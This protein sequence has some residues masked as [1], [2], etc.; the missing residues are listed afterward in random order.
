MIRFKDLRVADQWRELREINPMHYALVA[1]AADYAWRVHNRATVITS[2]YRPDPESVHGWWRGTDLRIEHRDRI[3]R[4]EDRGWSEDIAADTC[5]WLARAFDYG[6]GHEVYRI[7]GEGMN[8]H[9]H[10]QSP[11]AERWVGGRRGER[12]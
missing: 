6:V 12:E 4:E 7:H 2:I 9:V 8:R 11:A 3:V 1:A 10:L 5:T